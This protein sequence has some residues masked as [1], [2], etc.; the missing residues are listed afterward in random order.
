MVKTASDS[1]VG[2]EGRVRVVLACSALKRSYRDIIL[3]RGK[4]AR[5]KCLVLAVKKTF[6]FRHQQMV[7]GG[8]AD[9]Q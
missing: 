6:W 1:S 9:S 5:G 7:C 2:V 8:A 4:G 3:G